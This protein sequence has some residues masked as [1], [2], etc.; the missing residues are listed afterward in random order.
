MY[1]VWRE[2]GQKLNRLYYVKEVKI[3]HLNPLTGKSDKDETFER[4]N[5]G[6]NYTKDNK[7]FRVWRDN[8]MK[9]D[10]EKIK[11]ALGVE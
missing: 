4:T 8:Q 7:A 2:I 3:E 5:G 10:I 11:K 1:M 9:F 6:N